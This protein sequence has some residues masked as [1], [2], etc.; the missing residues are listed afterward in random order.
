MTSRNLKEI[1]FL[2]LKASYLSI[3]EEVDQAI[4]QVLDS[5]TY[6]L[7]AEVES[8]ETEWSH[9]CQSNFCVG[10]SNGLDAL[11]LALL[12]LDIGPGD[13]IIVPSNSFIATLLAVSST[14][15]TPVPV[16]P[17]LKTFNITA[18]NIVNAITPN[19]KAIIAV[20]LYG[21]PVDLDSILE[22][23]RKY[24]IYLIEDA[25]QAHG[26]LYKG[27]V[28]GAHSD[29]ICWSFYPAK[30]LGAFGDAGAITTN[31]PEI[32]SRI[33]L[34]RN[35]GSELKYHH[36][37]LGGNCRLDAL[38]ASVLRVKLR[39][40]SAAIQRRRQIAT[41]YLDNI[42]LSKLILP[43]TSHW[44]LHS[45]HLFVVRSHNR[46]AL[47]QHLRSHGIGSLIHYPI[48]PHRQKAYAS[49]QISFLEMPIADKLSAEV[50][51]LPMHPYLSNDEVF[52]IIDV[53]SSFSS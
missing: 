33:R 1:P 26:T 20:H 22:V 23:A 50:L 3:K 49:S 25:A 28:I 45:W 8:F 12:S 39:H 19:T 9:Y 35:Y 31:S 38:Q 15:A 53:V 37:S 18:E 48:P 30:T 13:E 41:Y 11:R 7:G 44:G 32:A 34:L 40:L 10:V 24:N 51:S 52:R 42:Q 27:Q 46:N 17:D 29:I 14:G 47:Q 5:G 4:R 43:T 16:E 21:H 2:D 36:V 6:V